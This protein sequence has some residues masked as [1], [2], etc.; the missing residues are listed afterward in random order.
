MPKSGLILR[1]GRVAN[2]SFYEWKGIPCVRMIGKNIKQTK[3]TIASAGLFG[4]AS[5]ITK[6]LRTLL[7]PVIAYPKDLDMQCRFREPLRKCL[8]AGLLQ[9]G[10]TSDTVPFLTGFEFNTRS[11]INERWKMPWQVSKTE[12]GL[13]LT[14]P[15]LNPAEKIVAPAYTQSVR[16][17]ITAAAVN[18]NNHSAVGSGSIEINIPYTN[19]TVEQK[20]WLPDIPLV[21]D[22]LLVLAVSLKYVVLKKGQEQLVID[23]RWMPAGIVWAGWNG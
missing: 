16:C 18:V 2:I 6:T 19:T 11:A 10:Q 9:K 5:S 23:K 20:Q 12:N 4:K 15:A 21:K 14:I 7:S 3:A 8:Q 22:S 1:K 17:C 13:L